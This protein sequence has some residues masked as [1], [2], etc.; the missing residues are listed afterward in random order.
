MAKLEE[1]IRQL[2]RNI[3]SGK[4]PAGVRMPSEADLAEEFGA[5]RI[6][7]NKAVGKL[8]DM[9][10]LRRGSSTR[11]G[12]YIRD[13]SD[14]AKG[15]LGILTHTENRYDSQLL[16]G[17][18]DA[19]S[20]SRYMLMIQS[21]DISEIRQA[22]RFM[23]AN[24]VQGVFL[25][26]YGD[27]PLSMPGVRIDSINPDART[28]NSVAADLYAGSA[29][30][31]EMLLEA[32]HRDIVFVVYSSFPFEKNPRCAAFYE[33]LKKYNIRN[34]RRHF[35]YT[36]NRSSAQL[37]RMIFSEFPDMTALIGENDSYAFELWNTLNRLNPDAAA[38]ITFCGFGN[39]TA[40]QQVHPFPTFDQ[41][42]YEI[43]VRAVELFLQWQKDGIFRHELIPGSLKNTHLIRKAPRH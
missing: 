14:L 6:T 15:T 5:N 40:V 1:I 22:E 20:R 25:A 28:Q 43:G 19:A 2:I 21:P 27:F 18:V 8:V 9:G 10:Y 29:E 35:V 17:V 23:Q 41:H 38:K 4:Y 7:L 26:G 36:N 42:P 31:A 3:E 11:D 32:G 30:M 39:L 33:M 34:P 13:R 24:R 16:Q 12:T 37:L